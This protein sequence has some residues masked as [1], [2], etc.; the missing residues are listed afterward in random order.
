M[1]TEFG[2]P[3]YRV[4][5][6]EEP[7]REHPNHHGA[8][9]FRLDVT[10]GEGA[11]AV[12]E[13]EIMP[14]TARLA[15]GLPAVCRLGLATRGNTGLRPEDVEHALARGIN[16]WNWC[17]KP[18]GMSQAIAGL[19]RARRQVVIAVQCEARTALEA[20]RELARIL[21]EL[22]TDYLDVATF[23]YVESEEE[24]QQIIGAGG[25]WE[26]LERQQRAGALQLIGLTSHQRR[27]A[28]RWAESVV[29]KTSAT[30]ALASDSPKPGR[31]RLDLL[32]IR[33]NAAHRGAEQEVFPVT[34]RCA[35]PVVTYT[36]LRW[37]ALLGPTPADPPGYVPPSATDCYRFCLAHPA[38]NVTLTAPGNRAELDENLALLEDW[39]PPSRSQLAEICRH[40]DRVK[41]HAGVFW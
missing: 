4:E 8:A 20:E 23:Y 2:P 39:Q 5:Q 7:G 13:T 27:L 3:R 24:W 33:Y 30:K 28:A 35:M 25:A 6:G 14:K 11:S 26:Y 38:V 10:P 15:P 17:G 16:Y 32:M 19:G 40:G 21:K 41:K 36:G 9:V 22:R 1:L 29:C 18:D 31:R 12:S 34:H 37:R